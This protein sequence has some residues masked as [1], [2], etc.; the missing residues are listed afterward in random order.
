MDN[1]KRTNYLEFERSHPWLTFRF[2]VRR[3]NYRCWM[4]LGAIQ[5][6]IEH[7]AHVMLPPKVRDQLHT[8]YLAKGIHATTAIEGNTLS[9]AEVLERIQMKSTL[10]QSQKYQAQEIDNILAACNQIANDIVVAGADC[11]LTVA[12]IKNF[13]ALVLN[14]LP[15]EEGIVPGRIRRR[16]VGVG[17]YRGAPPQ[18]CEH[19]LGC[20]CDWINNEFDPPSPDLLISFSILKAIIS[21]VY[22][23]W[24]HPFDDG[25]GRTARL[26]EVQILLAA[27]V[28]MIAAHLLSNHYNKTRTEYY[29]QLDRASKSGGDLVP[30][31]TYALQGLFDELN[32]QIEHI[33]KFQW[34]SVWKDYVYERFQSKK[35]IPAKRQLRI[36]LE[37]PHVEEGRCPLSKVRRLTPEIA[38]MYAGKTNKTLS[39]DLNDLAKME[40]IRKEGGQV[41]ANVEILHAFLSPRRS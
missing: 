40:L 31:I 41:S 6:K 19:L 28:P 18:D 17:T 2:D 25:N 7:V 14:G 13:D 38:E 8:L 11:D 33:R 5:S 35:G 3:L 34:S 22:L 36:A 16:S 10:P 23:A 30:F 37:L 27:G 29:R 24:I 15:L 39:R 32:T 4:H 1:N 12:G 26:V 20:L 9:E 21:H